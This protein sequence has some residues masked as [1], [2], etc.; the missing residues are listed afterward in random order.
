M[1]PNKNRGPNTARSQGIGSPND[2][3]GS[4]TPGEME[5]LRKEV[6]RLDDVGQ[7]P[8]SSLT[9]QLVQMA[10]ELGPSMSVGKRQ[11]ERN[12]GQQWGTRPQERS[13]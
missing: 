1:G 9:R 8:G 11:P 2:T 12:S 13:S 10:A 3:R 6:R 7:L 4:P 5:R